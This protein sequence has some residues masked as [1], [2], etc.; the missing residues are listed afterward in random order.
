M[1]GHVSICKQDTFDGKKRRNA[2]IFITVFSH[3]RHT[4]NST[5][6]VSKDCQAFQIYADTL[7]LF[8]AFAFRK[9]CLI[10]VVKLFLG[11]PVLLTMM[12]IMIDKITW[13]SDFNLRFSSLTASTLCDKS[14]RLEK[15]QINIKHPPIGSQGNIHRA[16]LKY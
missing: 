14:I 12:T 6:N 10:L 8:I 4:L 5:T 2:H 9:L 16:L 13:F 3:S 7:F 11:H 15:M 1:L